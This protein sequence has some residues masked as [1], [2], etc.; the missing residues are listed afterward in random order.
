M[1]DFSFFPLIETRGKK[2]EILW[3]N[4]DTVFPRESTKV[5]VMPTMKQ[6]DDMIAKLAEEFDFSEREARIFLSLPAD[7]KVPKR[8]ASQSP[9]PKPRGRPPKVIDTTTS[10]KAA[11]KTAN[12][13]SSPRGPSTYNL[14]VKAESAKVK[15]LLEKSAPGGKLERGAV[16]KELGARWK[17]MS[18]SQKAKYAN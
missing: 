15:A 7:I 18:D 6:V 3:Y 17:N 11:N 5:K 10:D 9:E 8:P 13:T 2:I 1:I 16:M 12:K 4:T 14:Y